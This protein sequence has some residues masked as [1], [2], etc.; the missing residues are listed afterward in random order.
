MNFNLALFLLTAPSLASGALRGENRALNVD[1]VGGF[2]ETLG[3]CT[4][5]TCGLWGDPHIVT[6]DGLT[7]DCQ[8]I[9]IFTLMKNDMFN[10]QANFVGVGKKEQAKVARWGLTMGASITNDVVI[11]F[12]NTINGEPVPMIQLGFGEIDVP[13]PPSENGCESMMTFSPTNMPGQ[14]RSVENLTSCRARCATVDGCTA[15]SYWADGGCHLNDGNQEKIASNPKWSRAVV[16]YMEADTEG[17]KCGAVLTEA[18]I[19]EL[20]DAD[21]SANH[22]TIGPNC[23][24]LM[25]V[26]GEMKDLSEVGADQDTYLLGEEGADYSVFKDGSLIKV[27][28]KISDTE[29]T[30]V[31][32]QQKGSGPGELWSCHWDFYVCLPAALENTL[33]ATASIGLLGSANGNTK[34]D[35]MTA[36][37]I[38]IPT[39]GTSHEDAFDY[40]VTNW[41]VS[42][43]DNIMIP[44]AGKTYED[45]KCEDQP[46]HP[47]DVHDEECVLAAD[48]I[49][50]ACAN[51]ARALVYA[52][53]LDCC[54]GG[55]DDNPFIPKLLS[56]DDEDIQYNVP[57]HNDCTENDFTKTGDDICTGESIVTLLKSTGGIDMPTNEPIIYGITA[58]MEPNDN[59]A[60]L[61]VN[62]KVNNPFGNEADV[63]VKHEKSVLSGA[64]TDEVCDT[65]ENVVAGCDMAAVDVVVACHHYPNITPF[66]LVQVYFAKSGA[67]GSATVDKC[68]TT[69]DSGYDDVV[70][71]TF[72]IQCEC[73]EGIEA[74]V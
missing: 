21:E 38:V 50:T 55:C 18:D 62:F 72:E 27:Q 39:I 56:E 11:D 68:C 36:D 25:Y 64:F 69:P 34:D 63:Y 6:C 10:I 66:A 31:H 4:G 32:L 12:K 17:N 15:F 30:E 43:E 14:S 5:A 3:M 35:W 74:A 23:P 33:T 59:S 51:K 58:N 61:T 9:G 57:V 41:C 28:Y 52:C 54:L 53:E 71:Y 46:Y 45:H 48:K 7:F 29:F 20:T 47:W 1:A 40:C 24:L 8:G 65:K 22:G 44:H 2:G 73:S 37:G 60:G 26:D 42:Q 70:M 19:P 16:G 13:A 67:N 49:I